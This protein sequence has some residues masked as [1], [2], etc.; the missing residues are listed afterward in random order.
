MSLIPREIIV[1][2]PFL[3][4]IAIGDTM[5]HPI[6]AAPNAID[7]SP[8]KIERLDPA[9]DAIVPLN[10]TWRRLATGFTWTEGPVWIH[11][12]YLLFA[13]IPSNSIR[14]FDPNGTISIWLQPSGY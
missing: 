12:G 10:V 6:K 13:D 8:A 2:A 14:K 5:M 3:L 11:S 1:S 4:A 7:E 9:L